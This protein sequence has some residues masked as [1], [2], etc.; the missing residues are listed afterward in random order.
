MHGPGRG[1]HGRAGPVAR[2]LQRLQPGQLLAPVRH[3]AVERVT[4]RGLA[5]PQGVVGVLHGE[6]GEP[7]V[8]GAGQRGGVERAQVADEDTRRPAVGDDVVERRHQDVLGRAETD[9]QDPQQGSGAQV[10]GGGLLGPERRVEGGG[11]FVHPEPG[12]IGL[13]HRYPRCALGVVHHLHRV[14]VLGAE[15]GPQGL[16][17]RHQRRHRPRQRFGVQLPGDPQGGRGVVLA[18]AGVELVQN[19]QTLLRRGERHDGAAP[20]ARCG[21]RGGRFGALRRRVGGR[22]QLGEDRPLE[23]GAPGQRDGG[24]GPQPGDDLEGE[25]RVAAEVEEVVVGADLAGVQHL[26]P[27][28]GE[29]PLGGG[30]GRGAGP[31]AAV[32]GGRC[33]GGQ[34]APVQLAVGGQRQ[35]VQDHESGR[36]HELR[37]PGGGVGAQGARVQGAAGL[38]DEVRDQAPGAR[39]VL[40]D[41]DD[42][43]A[44]VRVGGEH[45]LDLARLDAQSADLHLVVAAPAVLQGAVGAPADH[46]TGAVEPVRRAGRVG[47]EAGGG[48]GGPPVVAARQRPA[49]VQLAPG[50]HRDRPQRLVE[51]ESAGAGDGRADRVRAARARRER[52]AQGGADGGLGRA[53]GVDD[54]AAARRPAVDHVVRAALAADHEGLQLGQLAL[55]QGA[56]DDRGHHEVADPAP[57]EQAQQLLAHRLALGEDQG[58]A[59]GEGHQDVGHRHVETGRDV[60]EDP[61]AGVQRERVDVRGG[62]AGQARVRDDDALGAAGRTGGVDHVRRVVRGGRGRLAAVRAGRRRAGEPRQVQDAP[63]RGGARRDPL[64]VADEQDV[65]GAVVQDVGDAPGRV[66][67]V[68]RD[69][70]AARPHDREERRDLGG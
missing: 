5:L 20:G 27:D 62:Q 58:G 16:V 39:P 46:V 52:R 48:Q 30:P 65:R 12:E 55:G 15:D 49:E 44:D 26:G 41:G 43:A 70:H 9:R 25:D 66:A 67:G 18:A 3:L 34:G 23:Q 1:A 51:D 40:A 35:R 64:R 2:Q 4:G 68:D 32:G 28:R 8:R 22:R 69:V 47:G 59:G 10:E 57:G 45:R 53:V 29:G 63:G 11:A 19:P 24:G 50:A 36:D 42:G 60:L 21:R 33:G 61:A 54:P 6:R 38:R 14:A 13:A 31:V 7:R 56:E 17:A 37:Q